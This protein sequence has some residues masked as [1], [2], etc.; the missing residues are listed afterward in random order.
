MVSAEKLKEYLIENPEEIIKI[1]EQTDFY[2][3]SFFSG[4]SEIRC[5]YYEGGNPTSVCISCETLKTYVFSKSIGGDLFHIIA[6]HNNW[7]LNQTISYISQL[8]GVS[9]DNNFQIPYIFNGVYKKIKTEEK[10]NCNL[11]NECL[12]NFEFHPNLR[13]LKDNI[14]L[15]TQFK[16]NIRYD[17]KTNRIVVPWFNQNGKLVG[18]TGRYNFNDIGNYPKWKALCNFSKGNFLYGMFENK[19]TIENSDFV[20]IGESEKFVMQLDSFGYHNGLALGSCN[21]TDTQARLIKSLPVKKIILAFDE[22]VSVEHILIQCEKLKGG[23]FNN[24][25]VWC[26]YNN[27]NSVLPKGS[28][29]APSDF[30]KENFEILLNK[31]CF[32]KEN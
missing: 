2:S 13:F 29:A 21:I 28:K 26:I 32:K 10:N 16:F 15:E 18:I 20:I 22:G 19:E 5:A 12:D 9:E 1:L 30:G 4:K 11:S 7:T 27:D 14:T 8:L 3:I 31:Y 24:K 23:I 17:F 25:E 6:I